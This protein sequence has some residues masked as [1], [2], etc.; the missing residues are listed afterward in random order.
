MLSGAVDDGGMFK[1]S[2]A[3]ACLLTAALILA[4]PV[5]MAA[6]APN[7]IAPNPI[8]K[9]RLYADIVKRAVRLK[10][11][12]DRFAAKPA[13]ALLQGQA[14][15]AY[16]SDIRA[17]AKLDMQAHYD[18]IRRGTDRDLKCILMGV[19]RDLPIKLD[20]I[21]TARTDVDLKTAFLNMADLLEDNAG[22]ITAP[23][24][25]DSGVDCTLEFG[26]DANAL[27]AS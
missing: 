10:V 17:L 14:F 25:A 11:R 7:P 6:D 22:L 20:A 18:L 1:P 12:T 27:P 5:G 21:K 4:A 15:S 3:L 2:R 16:D 19:S 26:K 13:P 23:A 9:E 8:A 24:T